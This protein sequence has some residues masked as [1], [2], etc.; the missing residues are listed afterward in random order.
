LKIKR[1]K[2]VAVYDQTTANFASEIND[3]IMVLGFDISVNKEAIYAVA[4]NWCGEN[5]VTIDEL[6][7]IISS[8]ETEYIVKE[9]RRRLALAYLAFFGDVI[10]RAKARQHLG[11]WLKRLM[12]EGLR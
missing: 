8:L 12:I 2:K 9:T 1:R 4:F 7:G 6:M 3:E 10:E 5:G 11:A